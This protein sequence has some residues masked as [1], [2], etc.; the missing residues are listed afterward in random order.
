MSVTV[1]VAAIQFEPRMGAKEHNVDA[2]LRLADDAARAGA[3][4]ITTPEMATT[5]YCWRSRDEIAPEVEPVPGPTTARFAALAQ[6][7]GCH[8]V[9]GMPEVDP[10]T[11]LYYNTAVLIGPDGVIGRHRKSHP[12]ISEPKWAA[13]GDLG[14]QVFDT[15]VGRIGMLVCMDL[16][17]VETARLLRL[18]GAQILCHISNWLAE[19]TPAPYWISRA[20]ENGCYLVESNRWGLERGVQFSGG[21]CV[22]GRDGA[23]LATV[24]AGD[25][26]AYADL[27]LDETPDESA[28]QTPDESAARGPCAPLARRRPELYAGL[29]ANPFVWNPLDYFRLYGLDVLPPGSRSRVTAAQFAPLNDVDANLARIETLVAQ[30]GGGARPALLVLPEFAL[31]GNPARGAPALPAGGAAV[32]RLVQLAQRERLYLAAGLA[33]ADGER[34]YSTIVLAGPEGLVGRY[35]KLH[36]DDDDRAWATP[37]D[38]WCA[39]D[40]ALG[41]IGL[42]CGYDALFPESARL[43][44]LQGCDLIACASALRRTLVAA[45]PGSAVRQNYPIP[46]GADPHHWHH[47]RVRAGENN[48]YFAFANLRDARDGYTGGSGVFGPDTFAFPRREALVAGEAGLATLDV[49][50]TNLDSRYP[51]NV[52]R[53][54]DLVTMRLPHHYLPLIRRDGP[55]AATAGGRGA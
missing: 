4:L 33:E 49:D 5:G 36:L 48:V 13:P 35:R 31:S 46:T 1:K 12:Y 2:L 29:M 7:H 8:L 54:K 18:A 21:S 42:L 41:R 25:G 19:R 45:H 43:L 51:T 6:R 11:G 52:V 47:M 22:I 9:L 17:F 50:T 26:I 23:I 37:G 20:A 32:A 55:G 10:A 28:D 27:T 34:R 53:R 40:T 30:A 38:A 14:H 44:A 24:D 39:F 16:H 3:R 15:P